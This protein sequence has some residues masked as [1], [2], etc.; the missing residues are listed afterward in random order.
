MIVVT[1]DRDVTYKVYW[2]YSIVENEIRTIE[3]SVD[4]WLGSNSNSVYQFVAN[5]Y[6][7]CKPKDQFNKD[8]GRKLSLAKAISK[9]DKSTRT[10]FWKAY[11]A[12]IGF[13]HNEIRTKK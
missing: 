4:R 1:K 9:F 12:E 3:C 2:S 5:G 13:R 8:V 7:Y 10:A 11:E 6:A